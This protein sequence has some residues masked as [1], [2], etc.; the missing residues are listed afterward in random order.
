MRRTLGAAWWLGIA[1]FAMVQGA[2]AD[3]PSPMRPAP[4][5]VL[6]LTR[7]APARDTLTEIERAALMAG[8]TVSRPMLLERDDGRWVGGVSYQVV[9]ARPGVVLAAMANPTELGRM[10]P[11][12]KSVRVLGVAARGAQIE[13]TQGTEMVDAT[14]T[15]WLRRTGPR[16]L[17][18]RLDPKRPHGIR[19]VHGYLRARPFGRGQT[20]VTVA[21]ALDVGP[22]L[23]RAL[24]EDRIQRLILATPRH[25][26]D[27][28][29]PR[30]LA[31]AD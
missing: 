3:G 11:R 30:A 24:F 20:L 9:R 29:E 17:S 7:R 1:T 10:L 2:R 19:D 23:V 21:V 28:L 22:G 13:L 16:E 25:I 5:R 8:D 26:R 6:E 4:A 31:R 27:Y 15:V 14:Y 12:T 18:F